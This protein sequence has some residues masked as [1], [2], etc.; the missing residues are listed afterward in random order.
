MHGFTPLKRFATLACLVGTLH[1]QEEPAKDAAKDAAQDAAQDSDVLRLIANGDT[2]HG[3][4][5]GMKDGST[6]TWSGSS[7][8]NSIELHSSSL[9][10]LALNGGRAP[11]S[12]PHPEHLK[13]VNGD[14]IPGRVLNLDKNNVTIET[15]MSGT[16]TLDRKFV[17]SISPNPFGGLLH[18]MGPFTEENW[19]VVTPAKPTGNQARRRRAIEED[20]EEISDDTKAWE[21]GGDA[22]YSGGQL[23]IAVDANIPGKARIAFNLAWRSRLNAVIAF[24]AT[25]EVPELKVEEGEEPKP[26]VVGNGTSSYPLT[27]G[28]S[29]VLTIYSSYAMLYRCDFDE[30]GNAKMNRLTASSAT[31]HLEES[32]EASFDLRCDRENNNITLFVNGEY[33]NQWEDTR[34][35]AGTGEH[36][37][38]SCQNSSS[39]LRV[40]DVIVSSWNGMIDS[41]RSMEA[42]DRDTIL[43]SNGTDRFSGEITG[44][45]DGHYHL[46]GSYAEMQIPSTE[47]EEIR[48]ASDT[49]AELPAT[50]AKAV[51]IV[52]RPIGRLTLDPISSTA[53]KLTG[54]HPALEELTVDL[55][56][57]SLLEFSF[58]DSILDSWDDD[59]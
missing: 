27:Y 40:S 54:R 29:Y 45:H 52:L 7:L 23:P 28:H 42:E 53:N 58:S 32:G 38:F 8:K 37:A 41:A 55:G 12:L 14:E 33:V 1:A 13:L 57:A 49:R 56:Y 11:K 15:P 34:G 35:Y 30:D 9:R 39:R 46:K 26:R 43:L 36:L 20:D 17:T 24:H 47:V 59:F 18:Y 3:S 51:R 5:V 25:M 31:I 44:L 21:F 16:I 48:F 10:R 19:T 6:L 50:S 4:F 22:W 2:L